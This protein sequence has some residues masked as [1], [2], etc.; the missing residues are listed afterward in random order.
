[1]SKL[2]NI[3]ILGGGTS[4]WF[5][6]AVLA[7]QYRN[8]PINIE[9]VESDQIGIIGVGEATIPPFLDAL[10][11]IGIDEI[12]FIKTTQATFKLAIK[13]TG[14]KNK[15]HDYLHP[16]GQ[17]G[18]DVQY[19]NFYQCFLK[20]RI[21]DPTLSLIDFSPSGK[22]CES[23]KFVF[24]HQAKNTAAEA[25]AF[26]LHLDAKLAAD[27]FRRHAEKLG[28]HRTEGLVKEVNL[29][30]EGF[31]ESLVL[32]S[33]QIINGDFFFD[34]SG[35]R[36]IIIGGALGGEFE[37][38]SQYLTVNKAV[39]LPTKNEPD[40]PCFTESTAQDYGWSWR[41]P[42]QTRTGN[43]YVFDSNHCSVEEA[44]KRLLEIV[45]GEPIGEPQLV[46]FKTGITKQPWIKNCIAIG[47][48]GGFLEP[49]ES[50]AIHMI[51]R[52]IKH[53]IRMIPN[54]KYDQVLVNE[55]NRRMRNDF[56]EIR[57][58]LILHYVTT[59]RTDT[60]F[61]QYYKSMSLPESLQYKL[62][63]FRRRGLLVGGEDDLFL[64]D[65]WY[66][67]LDGMGVFPESYDPLLDTINFSEIAGL[68]KQIPGSIN[69]VVRNL[70]THQDFIE[71]VCKTTIAKME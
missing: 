28:V 10:R 64:S 48:A 19:Q 69:Q 60:P 15:Q 2:K 71:R 39:T 57:D 26:A 50:T 23:N 37:D 25:S 17:L 1:M 13:F 46:H 22:M 18:Q 40:L 45:Q 55:Y 6:A 49:L 53:F 41:I 38:W 32:E 34:C 61:W 56:E 30:D 62:A 66:A 24:P 5:T 59:E 11:S 29:D 42:L 7:F 14:W 31:V 47:L 27:Y 3:V 54:Q 20:M 36:S 52:G 65:N 43:G 63:L 21:L 16:F 58:F 68:L 9:L 12:D 35:F 8:N 44:K 4:G 70:P 51:T 67:V 33:K